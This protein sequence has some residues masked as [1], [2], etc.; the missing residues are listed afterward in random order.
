MTSQS[1]GE[2]WHFD[3]LNTLTKVRILIS[4]CFGNLSFSHGSIVEHLKQE[5]DNFVTIDDLTNH[6]NL[7][8]SIPSLGERRHFD[9]LNTIR[10]FIFLRSKGFWNMTFSHGSIVQH[11]K[12][13]RDNFVTI[14]VI[15]RCANLL[16]TIPCLGEIRHFHTLNTLSK[17]RILISECFGNL[18]FSLG[19]IVEHYR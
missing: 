6:T 3:A 16:K 17:V 10:N 7:I 2:K 19:S 11:F 18:S 15:S 4:K 12:Q 13:E 14:I 9:A 1:L 8:L 5:S